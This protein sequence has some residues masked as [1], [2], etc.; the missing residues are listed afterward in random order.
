MQP[1]GS[2]TYPAHLVAS[3]ALTFALHTGGF[4]LLSVK[5]MEILPEILQ[6]RSVRSFTRE[7]LEKDQVE[8]ILEAG[9][10]APSGEKPAGM[11]VRRHPEERDPAEDDGGRLQPGLR[12]PGAGSSSRC[13]RRTSTTACPTASFPTPSTWRSPPPTS[14]SRPCTRAWAHAASRTFDEQEVRDILTAPFSMRVVL[15]ILVGTTTRA[16]AHTAQSR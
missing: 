13:A 3:R 10:L 16:R 9:R 11:A 5:A 8:R 15:L 4:P 7:P 2:A 6:R 1:E 12:R 14:S